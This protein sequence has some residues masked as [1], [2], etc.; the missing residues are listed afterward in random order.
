MH[1]IKRTIKNENGTQHLL[2]AVAN[3]NMNPNY[4]K[5]Y[6]W[7]YSLFEVYALILN[8]FLLKV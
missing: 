3:L 6:C 8:R 2:V 7:T 5:N 4:P 1:F